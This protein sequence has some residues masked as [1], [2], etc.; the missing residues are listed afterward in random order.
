MD[1]GSMSGTRLATLEE[2]I[3]ADGLRSVIAAALAVRPIDDGSLRRGVWA[4]VCGAREVGTPP[5]EV[6]VTL[7]GLVE[8]SSV[9]PGDLRDSVV[10]RVIL[11]CVDAY[12]GH[13]GERINGRKDDTAGEGSSESVDRNGAGR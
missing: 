10:R 6:I 7:T 11:W 3:D 5:G 1:N 2:L 13:I 9:A 8:A 12:F 4:Y